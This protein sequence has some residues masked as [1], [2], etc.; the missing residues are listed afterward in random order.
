MPVTEND[1]DTLARRLRGEAR[2]KSPAGKIAV[3]RTL[4]NRVFD[5]KANSWRG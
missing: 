2:G 4:R 3:A 5:G 1:R